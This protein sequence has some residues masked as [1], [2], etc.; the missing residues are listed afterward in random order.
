[1][2]FLT[3][4]KTKKIYLDVIVEQLYKELNPTKP[5]EYKEG[6]VPKENK[7]DAEPISNLKD[8][9]ITLL[10]STTASTNLPTSVPAVVSIVLPAPTSATKT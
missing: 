4:S 1:L 5:I 3:F 6:Y 8:K 10:I 2:L 7:Y 9:A